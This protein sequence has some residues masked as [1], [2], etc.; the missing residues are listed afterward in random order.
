MVNHGALSQ[1]R[2]YELLCSKDEGST[3]WERG[4][5]ESSTTGGLP[6]ILG[7]TYQSQ[8][9]TSLPTFLGVQFD[10]RL[11]LANGTMAVTTAGE[12]P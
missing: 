1:S 5:T 3:L 6:G 9:V 11:A 7:L 10:T 8:T 12:W 2:V 4:F